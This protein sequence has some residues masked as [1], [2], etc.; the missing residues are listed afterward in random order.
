MKR[1]KIVATIG[2][3][4]NNSDAIQAL[5]ASGMDV[6]RLNGSHA[7][8]TWHA[9]T[10]GLLRRMAPSLPILLDI[11][12]RK[13]RTRQLSHEPSFSVGD[14][15]VLTTSSGHDGREKVPVN[16]E[17]LHDHL[18]P[19]D[20]VFADDGTL[21]FTVLEVQGR[22]IRCRAEAAGTLR[23]AKGIN[24]PSVTFEGGSLTERDMEMIEF[25][26]EHGIDYVGI[27]FVDS[28]RLVEEV[29]GLVGPGGPRVLS[30]VENLGGMNN[31][32][33]V[34]DASDAIMIDRGDLSVE[35]NLES[36]V[37][38]QKRILE[39]ARTYGKP[40]IVATEMLHSMIENPFPTKA[41]VSDISNAVLDGAA[42]LMLSG[43]TAVGRYPTQA[44]AL[45][46][47]VADTVGESAQEAAD[48]TQFLGGPQAMA[49]AVAMLCRVLPI[50]KIVPI[51]I[52]GYAARMV[53]NSRPRQPILAVSNQVG[54]ARSMNLLFGTEG[55]HVDIPFSPTNTDHIPLCLEELW[56]RE[57]LLDTDVVVVTSVGYPKSG[58]RMNMIATHLVSDIRDSLGWKR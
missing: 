33:E 56:R 53:A 21:R 35:T 34:V 24:V 22:D 10:I 48:Q 41:E 11:P 27:S 54:T 15:I 25:A 55:I 51:T 57:Y 40:V 3:G 52:S 4:T 47:S 39:V 42:A 23:S 8:L 31:L 1:V 13:I 12:G 17:D 5:L 44:V 18:S 26:C 46:R 58:N 19:G 50:T 43:E 49:D 6:A 9:A 38:Q 20:T 16:R 45:M 28:A 32:N 2:P 37:I 36:I 30:K 14:S 29:R 7:D